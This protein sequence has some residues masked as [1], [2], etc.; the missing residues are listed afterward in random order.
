MYSWKLSRTKQLNIYNNLAINNAMENITVLD[1]KYYENI[2]QSDDACFFLPDAIPNQPVVFT[3]QCS[4][5]IN[6]VQNFNVSRVSNN[7][8]L[9]KV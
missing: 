3:G 4:E 6:V 8:I 2:D 1:N 9:E 7:I 5:N